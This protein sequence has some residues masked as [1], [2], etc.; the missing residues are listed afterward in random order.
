MIAAKAICFAEAMTPAY[1]RYAKQVILNAQT[2][3]AEA[4]QSKA[5]ASY[6]E[7]QIITVS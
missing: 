7:A 3:A 2:L 5:I 6:P 1:K 4:L